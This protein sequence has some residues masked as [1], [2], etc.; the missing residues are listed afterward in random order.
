MFGRCFERSRIAG[1]TNEQTNDYHDDD[2]ADNVD[3]DNHILQ[4]DTELS[5]RLIRLTMFGYDSELSRKHIVCLKKKNEKREKQFA[6][7]VA[8]HRG[9]LLLL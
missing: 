6:Y 3:V 8:W 4:R 9:C 1:R 2:D 5:A 7:A